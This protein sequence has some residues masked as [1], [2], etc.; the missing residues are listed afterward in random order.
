MSTTLQAS[1]LVLPRMKKQPPDLISNLGQVK[2]LGSKQADNSRK[3]N[4]SETIRT[5]KKIRK[6]I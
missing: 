4:N 5:L 2:N 3:D 1:M 6:Q